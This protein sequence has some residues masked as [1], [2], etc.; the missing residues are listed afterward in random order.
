MFSV[1]EYELIA[2]GLRT[3]S[4]HP[5]QPGLGRRLNNV[6][7]LQTKIDSIVHSPVT[8]IILPTIY[9]P[10]RMFRGEFVKIFETKRELLRELVPLI[11]ETKPQRIL[12]SFPEQLTSLDYL[13]TI[14]R[15]LGPLALK[16]QITTPPTLAFESGA[17]LYF[18]GPDDITRGRMYDYA[19]VYN[20][21]FGE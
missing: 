18:V 3:G 8:S 16:K 19:F 6:G 4:F 13:N 17:V 9:C 10:P 11:C 1:H 21:E 14:V 15:Y 2:Q 7:E 12:L 20:K 5:D